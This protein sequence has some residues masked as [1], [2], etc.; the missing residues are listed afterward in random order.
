MREWGIS[1]GFTTIKLRAGGFPEISL[2]HFLAKSPQ[3]GGLF[4]D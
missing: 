3:I 1:L 4:W 2:V